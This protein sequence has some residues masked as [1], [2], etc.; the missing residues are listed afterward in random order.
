MSRSSSESLGNGTSICPYQPLCVRQH[1]AW[2]CV[3]LTYLSAEH[4]RAVAKVKRVCLRCKTRGLRADGKC[5][6][7]GEDG[8]QEQQPQLPEVQRLQPV[9][10]LVTGAEEGQDFYEC[11]VQ[12]EV[13]RQNPG[14]KEG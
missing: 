12:A 9:W 5:S 13:A 2:Q 14:P 7:C 6:R 11:Q 8:T 1:E 4:K 10:S 3:R